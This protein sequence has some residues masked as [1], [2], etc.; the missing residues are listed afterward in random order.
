MKLEFYKYSATPERVDKSQFLSKIGEINGV[1][2]KEDTNLMKP[3]FIL[4]TNPVAYNANYM[5]CSFTKRWYYINNVTA[6]TGQRIAVDGKIDV[7]FTYRKEILGS[8]AWVTKSSKAADTASKYDML[9]NDYPFRQ[10]YYTVGKDFVGGDNPLPGAQD[11]T[12]VPP[13]GFHNILF[14]IK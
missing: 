14:I 4:K 9:H 11:D 2:I 8:S 3:T 6:L 12:F 1:V 5:Y 13:E 7:L 10:D